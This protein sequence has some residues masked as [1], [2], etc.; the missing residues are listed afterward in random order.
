MLASASGGAP[1]AAS[2]RAEAHARACRAPGSGRPAPRPIASRRGARFAPTRAGVVADRDA[3]VQVVAYGPRLHAAGAR[4][5]QARRRP[6]DRG[7]SGASQSACRTASRR[8]RGR[9]RAA[10]L[11]TRLG[12]AGVEDAHHRRH[13][14]EPAVHALGVEDLRHQHAVGQR[15]ACRRGRS[16]RSRAAGELALDRLQ[17]GL[18]PVAVP[19]VLVVLR[20]LQLAAAGSAARA[21]CSS[22][23]ISQAMSSASA[24]TRARPS[25]SAGSS[26]GSGWVS[27][28]YSMIASDCVISRVAVR[29]RR[30]GRHQLRRRERANA[31]ASCSFLTQVHR[32]VVVGQALQRQR[33]AH[34]VRGRRAEVAVELHRRASPRRPDDLQLR[35]C[36][37]RRPARL[38]HVARPHRGRRLRACR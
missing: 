16:G 7:Q 1:G 3:E 33:D 37:R 15:R 27:S 11:R 29:R 17:A 35:A 36:R 31:G 30:R 2:A 28:R 14:V 34:P 22:G 23:W 5:H 32:H 9:P 13:V 21:G 6:G 4:G 19:A 12:H 10:S 8:R 18:D 24:R 38:Q 25:A 26:G 20:D